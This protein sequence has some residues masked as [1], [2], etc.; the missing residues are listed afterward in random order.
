M[1]FRDELMIKC[2]ICGKKLKFW[3]GY[4]HP[5]L[6]KKVIVC[7]KCFDNLNESIDRYREFILKDFKKENKIKINNNSKI[8]YKNIVH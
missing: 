7:S 2:N 3:N 6:G 5:I 8:K 1:W 4:Y